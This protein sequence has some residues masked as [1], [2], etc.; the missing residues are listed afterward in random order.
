[1]LRCFKF[2]SLFLMLS[3]GALF[4]R[5]CPGGWEVDL[6]YLYLFPTVDDTY[7]V[8]DAPATAGFPNGTRENNDFGFHS[9]FRVGGLM[10][11]V[12][13]ATGM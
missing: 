5:P 12:R 13:T 4:A 6:E 9:G 11:F 10:H 1:M 8:L 7:F 2:F 3:A